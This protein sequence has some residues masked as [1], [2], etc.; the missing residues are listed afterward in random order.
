MFVGCALVRGEFEQLWADSACQG[1]TLLIQAGYALVARLLAA[2]RV[3]EADLKQH[4]KTSGESVGRTQRA[5]H[6]AIRPARRPRQQAPEGQLWGECTPPQV[7][8]QKI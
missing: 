2:A 5:H 8:L 6:T 1:G 7:R 4:M 3:Y